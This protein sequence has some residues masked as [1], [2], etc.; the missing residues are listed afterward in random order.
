MGVDPIS[1]PRFA[2][3]VVSQRLGESAA[4]VLL[5]P[6]Q[7][8]KTTLAREIADA[9]APG[10]VY[11]DL[12]RPS[13]A[14]RLADA[15]SYLRMLPPRLGVI[16]E[17]QRMPELFPIL[18][19]VVD[20]NRRS[21]FGN[22]QFLL[23]GSAW[24]DL[25][26][27]ATE[28][29]AGRVS[30]VELTGVNVDEAAACGI[31]ADTLWL[32]GGFPT[33][34]L[35]SSD[36]SSARWR[37]DLITSYLER[38]VTAFAPRIPAEA[39]RRLWTMLAHNSGGLFNAASL[40]TSMGISG[41]TIVRYL[42]LLVDL[43]VVRRLE[44][45]FANV[46]KRVTKSPK[47]Y[48][49]DTGLLHALLE[50]DTLHDLLGHPSVGGSFE[51]FAIECLINAAERYRPYFYRSAR[52]DEVDLILVRGGQP[53]VAIE[54]KRSSAATVGAGFHRACDDLGI[55]TRYLVHS[56][57]GGEPYDRNGITVIGL[58]SLVKSFR[59]GSIEL[60]EEIERT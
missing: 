9:W 39:L 46:G 26:M 56:D 36:E 37:T 2:T 31:D 59:G 51:S 53:C 40:G 5:G 57:D 45:W 21:G 43:G 12:E 18:R 4:V 14:R 10:M 11:L 3:D 25:I 20:D 42:D 33:A 38:D 1:I 58:T 30:L 55:Q 27:G 34:L 32:R 8:G 6:R 7:V 54:I 50:L 19:S 28:S 23:L 24:L 35:A 60:P 41:P 16:D 22:G 49:R 13:D 15:D 44:P 52:Q 47:I 17:A 29:L 48:V